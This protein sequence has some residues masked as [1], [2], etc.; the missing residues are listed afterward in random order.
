MDKDKILIVED[1]MITS[2]I[3]KKILENKGYYITGIVDTSD[4]IIE[5]IEKE[6]P[7]L[8]L[9]DIVIKGESNGIESARII[10]DRYEIPVIYLTSDS[11]DQTIERA[12]DTEPFGYLIKPLNEKILLT[13]IGLAIRKQNKHNKQ[14]LETLRKANDE[15]ER[16][17]RERTKDLEK[18]NE[19]L[20]KEIRQRQ[21]AEENLK[22]SERL[23]MIGKMSAVLAHEIRNPLNSIKINADILSEVEALSE[24]NKR[25]IQIIQKEV[26]RLDSL[27]KEVLMFSRQS[28]LVIT[29]FN[30]RSF[31]DGLISQIKPQENQM[32]TEIRNEAEDIEIRGDVEKLKQVFLN[33]IINATEAVPENGEIKLKTE[34]SEDKIDILV[35]DNGYGVEYPDKVF[36]PF[37]TTKSMG[38]GLGLAVSQNIVE[39]HK[40]Q[41]YIK[42]TRP[43]ET[44]FCISL[45]IK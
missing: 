6:R 12:K 27:V 32:K 17:V 7:D 5:S 35:I 13:T 37:F 2:R 30:I 43:G 24:N 29:P 26:N 31:L 39:Q 22:K 21:L 1:D 10:R 40:G 16:R 4:K 14:I 25:R 34:K 8:I 11:S 19:E 36:E 38:T 33:I 42:S 28:T 15:L 45:P 23:A 18:A 44:I 20:K 3:I 41:L 9:M